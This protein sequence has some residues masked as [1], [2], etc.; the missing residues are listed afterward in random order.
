MKVF[1]V[2]IKFLGKVVFRL[3]GECDLWEEEE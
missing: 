3:G 2:I 1:E